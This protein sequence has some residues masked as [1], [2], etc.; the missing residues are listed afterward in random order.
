MLAQG[1]PETPDLSRPAEVTA[2]G[3]KRAR[4][5]TAGGKTLGMSEL[6]KA[7]DEDWLARRAL[8]V[9]SNIIL[10]LIGEY[11]HPDLEIRE[12]VRG[13]IRYCARSW[14]P[15]MLHLLE[16]MWFG[17]SVME[18]LWETEPPL[19][20]EGKW[21]LKELRPVP[22]ETLYPEGLD[23]AKGLEQETVIQNK[24]KMDERVLK[25][26]NCVHYAFESASD[27]FGNPLGRNVWMLTEG[28]REMLRLWLTGLE[29]VG[30]P[31]IL[32]ITGKGTVTVDGK[33]KERTQIAKES[34]DQSQGGSVIIREAGNEDGS[35]PR[36][37]ALK[38]SGW[39][40]EFKGFSGY[41]DRSI[42]FALGVLPLLVLE[43]EHATR[44]QASTQLD[45]QQ[46]MSVPIA[47]EMAT[48]VLVDQL[49]EPLVYYNYGEQETYGEFP[50]RPQVDEEGIAQILESLGRTG[51]FTGMP[52]PFYRRMQEQFPLLLPGVEEVEEE[53]GEEWFGGGAAPPGVVP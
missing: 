22:Q 48:G 1:R 3:G 53:L 14:A 40:Q 31:Y 47:K 50:V 35:L 46:V 18:M 13:A 4:T 15:A 23:A 26:Q 34:W 32:E 44:A 42:V 9:S 10:S 5:I 45:V 19:A 37:E 2:L 25:G 6:R 11:E 21:L 33:R 24:G 52:K 7:L 49:V 36:I 39:D 28:G 51:G 38:L 8:R 41:R 17:F 29:N 30:Q 27:P 12:F 43:P 16:G 20:Y